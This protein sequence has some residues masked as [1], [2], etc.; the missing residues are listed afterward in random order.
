MAKNKD[1]DEEAKRKKIAK[2]IEDRLKNDKEAAERL[3]KAIW[4]AEED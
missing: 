3:W 1:D 2:E 4:E